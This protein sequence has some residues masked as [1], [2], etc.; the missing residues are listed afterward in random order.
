MLLLDTHLV[1][2]AAM[3]PERLSTAARRWIEPRQDP[4]AFSDASLWE[5]AIKASLGKAG[6]TVDASA[7]RKGLLSSGFDD[8]AIRAEHVIAVAELPWYHR[9]R[10]IACLSHR[11]PWRVAR[12]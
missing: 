2:W 1:L 4:V 5:V 12:C 11:L 7:L 10:S 8:L 6:F 9:V 3:A